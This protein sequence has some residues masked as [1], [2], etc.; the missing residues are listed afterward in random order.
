MIFE[1]QLFVA[2]ATRDITIY[3]VLYVL[4]LYTCNTLLKIYDAA[5]E[6]AVAFLI[7]LTF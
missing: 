1:S 5:Y 4:L 7:Y 2:I 6:A 3:T